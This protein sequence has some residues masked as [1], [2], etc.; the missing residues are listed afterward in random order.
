M[1]DSSDIE[2]GRE[3][4]FASTGSDNPN[5]KDTEKEKKRKTNNGLHTHMLK[6]LKSKYLED[7]L[8]VAVCM[9][10]ASGLLP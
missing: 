6:T 4:S 5:Q 7:V 3:P 10:V 2:R 9:I 8:L 1:R